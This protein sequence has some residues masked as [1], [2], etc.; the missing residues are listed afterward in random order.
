MEWVYPRGNGRIYLPVD[1]DALRSRVVFE[2]I[3]RDAEST[4]YWYLDDDYLGATRGRHRMEAQPSAGEHSL[5][6]V[7]AQGERLES[8]LEVISRGR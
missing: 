2:A 5:L 8:K 1:L 3:H 4:V 7:D 6:L